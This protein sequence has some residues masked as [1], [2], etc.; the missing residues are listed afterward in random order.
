MTS[1]PFGGQWTKEKLEILGRYLDAYTT[2]LKNQRFRLIYVDAFAGEGYWR[3]GGNDASDAYGGYRGV[4]EGS[5]RIALG[6]RDKPFDRLL[7]IEKDS[8]RA[9][10]LGALKSEY[11]DR[12]IHVVE[13]DA[14]EKVIEFCKSMGQYDRAV[15]FLDP[16]ATQVSWPTVE[17]IAA[18]KKIDCWILF[19]LMAIARM[20]PTGNEPDEATAR[21]LDRIFGGREQ[22]QQSYED[23]PQLSLWDDDP[24]RERASGSEWIADRYRERLAS[25][26]YKVAPARRTLR[27]SKKAPLFELIFAS[28]NPKGAR[29]AVEIADHLLKNW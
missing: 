26:F 25:V 2:A 3:P 17:A 13:G 14:N 23:S 11:P 21:Q 10:S 24:G 1:Q 18:S 8:A 20:M 7:F 19:P 22:W 6:V 27:N 16:Y 9:A 29:T 15:V 28:S 4:L 5:A 12:D